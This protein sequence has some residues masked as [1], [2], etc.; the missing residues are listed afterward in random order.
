[1]PPERAVEATARHLAMMARM[2]EGD[3]VHE[4][5]KSP[6]WSCLR[7]LV[8]NDVL[9]LQATTLGKVGLALSGGGFRATLFH[10]G[11]MARLAELDALRY[12]EV[13]SCVSGGSIVGAH[14]YLEVR[15]LLQEKPD[16]EITREDYIAIVQ[17]MERDLLAG[18]QRNIRWRVD[19]EALTL[20]RVIFDRDYSRTA[21][22][23]ELYEKEIY[24]RVQDDEVRR[25]RDLTIKPADGQEHFHPTST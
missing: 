8:G 17:R 1:M 4:V 20:L 3:S 11:V 6:A 15:K 7:A 5:A 23:G 13:I 19:S 24:A 21:R 14:Y 2:Q 18:I 10:V 22:A 25:L 9:A 16:A 12:V